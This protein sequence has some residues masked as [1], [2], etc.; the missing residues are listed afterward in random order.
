MVEL[1]LLES[2]Y[3]E[4]L[5][6]CVRETDGSTALHMAVRSLQPGKKK[7]DVLEALLEEAPRNPEVLR[8][9][10]RE[11]HSPLTLARDM[12]R[13]GDSWDRDVGEAVEDYYR[14]VCGQQT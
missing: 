10:D 8:I 2:S 12:A 4:G 5:F 6:R 11:G 1:L 13:L 14:K 9:C 3:V 7:L